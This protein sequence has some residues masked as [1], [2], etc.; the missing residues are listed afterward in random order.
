VG[1][2]VSPARYS[3]EQRR[4]YIAKMREK[5]PQGLALSKTL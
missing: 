4:R 2:G 5:V 3:A 1:P